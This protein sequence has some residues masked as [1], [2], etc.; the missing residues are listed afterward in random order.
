VIYGSQRNFQV[1][2]SQLPEPPAPIDGADL[3]SENFYSSYVGPELWSFYTSTRKLL[4]MEGAAFHTTS[5]LPI[6]DLLD[7]APRVRR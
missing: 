3:V 7:K 4:M 1:E 2:E 6:G 5:E